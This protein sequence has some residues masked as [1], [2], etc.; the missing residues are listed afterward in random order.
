[1][2]K[3]KSRY[4]MFEKDFARELKK[5][6]K[7][8]FARNVQLIKGKPD[9]VFAGIKAC[10]FLDSDFWHG[11]QYPRWKHLLKND[12]WR[13]KI[14]KN[15]TRDR[16]ITTYLRGNGWRVLRIWEHSIKNNIGLQVDKIIAML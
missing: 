3:I 8:R 11:W 13:D 9:I 6:T 5:R 16:N 7:H 1:M 14:E 10:V 12:F 15:R 2:S 4:T